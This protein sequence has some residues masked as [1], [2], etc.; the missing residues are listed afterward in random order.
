MVLPIILEKS[1]L[2][3]GSA[4]TLRAFAIVAVGINI[5]E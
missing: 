1:L 3:Y 4:T 2:R 5:N